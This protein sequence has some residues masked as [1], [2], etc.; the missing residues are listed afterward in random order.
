MV[1]PAM[2]KWSA[3]TK[4][5]SIVSWWTV[6]G[7]LVDQMVKLSLLWGLPELRKVKAE[8]L[9][10]NVV[11]HGST[12]F[13]KPGVRRLLNAPS[14]MQ[15]R[16]K[17]ITIG[18]RRLLFTAGWNASVPDE[19]LPRNR[20]GITA[21]AVDLVAD[22]PLRPR[23]L[24]LV[25]V[26]VRCL[27]D[28]AQMLEDRAATRQETLAKFEQSKRPWT[29][30]VI[31]TAVMANKQSVHISFCLEE[32][33]RAGTLVLE[34]GWDDLGLSQQLR[35]RRRKREALDETPRSRRSGLPAWKHLDGLMFGALSNRKKA[36]QLAS[37]CKAT[38][39]HPDTGSKMLSVWAKSCNWPDDATERQAGSSTTGG[40]PALFVSVKCLK[41]VHHKRRA[42]QL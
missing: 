3:L 36:V 8:V 42:N 18:V 37:Y 27:K 38:N 41:K 22:A 24:G 4:Q 15:A 1:W 21:G 31:I 29:H 39:L 28:K 6:L 34:M 23:F 9:V 20:E 33:T 19:P 25:E 11:Q 30:C 10:L 5:V 14:Q 32:V 35:S 26:K 13:R 12:T 16:S 40:H 17:A 7:L 2:S